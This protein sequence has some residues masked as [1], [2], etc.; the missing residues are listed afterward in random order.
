MA[1]RGDSLCS[2]LPQLLGLRV[3][4]DACLPSTPASSQGRTGRR[5]VLVWM[6]FI[7]ATKIKSESAKKFG[8]LVNYCST[9]VV[10]CKYAIGVQIAAGPF[11]PGD[12]LN[13]KELTHSCNF[14]GQQTHLASTVHKLAG[15]FNMLTEKNYSNGSIVI[16]TPSTLYPS[17]MLDP[18]SASASLSSLHSSKS[19]PLFSG[20]DA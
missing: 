17:N 18:A 9:T 12:E 3:I 14:I 5:L 2:L 7:A 13:T 8:S 4:F 6:K 16:D 11:Q 20:V 19:G 1:V 10:G 15:V